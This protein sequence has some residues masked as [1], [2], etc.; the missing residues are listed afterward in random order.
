MVCLETHKVSLQPHTAPIS[1]LQR[2]LL[3]L[4]SL[5]SRTGLLS[6]RVGRRAFAFA[7]DLYKSRWEAAEIMA[8]KRFVSP[9]T[10]II[11]VGANIGFFT[12]RFAEW[13]RPGGIV[14]AIEPEA[15]NFAS[16]TA[17]ISRRGLVNVE[18]IQAVAAES[19]GTLKLHVNKRH[20]GDHRISE[21]GTE[22]RAVTLDGIMEHHGWPRVSLVKI[23]VQGAEERVLRGSIKT[24][25]RFKPAVSIE[26]DEA[27]LTAMGSNAQ[28]VLEMMAAEGYHVCRVEAGKLTS[29][30]PV[31]HV[32]SLCRPGRYADFVLVPKT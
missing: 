4:Y 27:A 19:P 12:R 31:K 7:Y 24:I 8:L 3:A 32:L 5:V 13:V 16:L 10:V 2:I 21:S 15:R 22:V 6:T 30:L 9:G 1:G 23:D 26:L 29:A 28:T 14:I 17:M 18:P 20:P 11:D 25:Q